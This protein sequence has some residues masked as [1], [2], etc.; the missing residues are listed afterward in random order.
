MRSSF[1]E[2][3]RGTSSYRAK[4]RMQRHVENRVFFEGRKL[5]EEALQDQDVD[6]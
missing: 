3:S 1:A 2:F 5:A 4:P 6:D